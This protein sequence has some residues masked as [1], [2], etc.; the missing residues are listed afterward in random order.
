MKARSID[1]PLRFLS[2]LL[3]YAEDKN[4]SYILCAADFQKA[5][6]SVEHNFIIAVLRHFGFGEDFIR[7]ITMMLTD[8]KSCVLNNGY[9]TDFFE[10]K[11]GTKQGDP[12][13]PYLFILVIE[14]LAELIRSNP[15]VH[16]VKINKTSE[17]IKIVLF[18]DDATLC[19]KDVQSLEESLNMLEQFK[20]YSSLQLNLEKSEVGWIG[21]QKSGNNLPEGIKKKINFHRE[22]IKILGIYFSHNKEDLSIH[23]F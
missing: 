6:D 13:S 2:D 9:V 21:P 12:I 4:E 18:A 3:E 14:I 19:L 16:G 23:N 7:W 11:R 8:I 20:K 15:E 22:G 10:L 1:E 5:F 17:E